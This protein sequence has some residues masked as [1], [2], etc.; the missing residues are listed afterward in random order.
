MNQYKIYVNG[1]YAGDVIAS[2][3]QRAITK[4]LNNFELP[5]DAEIIAIFFKDRST[6]RKE[7]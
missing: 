7:E 5:D 3:N 6:S 1:Q 2:S 4:A